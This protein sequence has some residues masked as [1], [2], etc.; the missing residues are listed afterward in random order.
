MTNKEMARGYFDQ[1]DYRLQ[2]VERAVQD[3]QWAI[4]VRQAQEWVE[5]ALKAVLRLVG[6]EPP[7]WHDVGEVLRHARSRFPGWFQAEVEKLAD[8]SRE[9]GRHCELSFY[10]DEEAGT[11]PDEIYREPEAHRALEDARVV[12]R[13]CRRLIYHEEGVADERR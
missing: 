4:A 2:R 1:A 8:I 7:C 9:R 6:V 12:C 5:Q 11:P 3:G 13:L 10:G